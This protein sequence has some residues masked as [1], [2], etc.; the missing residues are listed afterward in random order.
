MFVKERGYISQ[1]SHSHYQT[2]RDE[3]S[4]LEWPEEYGLVLLIV[5]RKRKLV[6]TEKWSLGS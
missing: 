1:A 4:V 6:K 3:V 5:S 2:V